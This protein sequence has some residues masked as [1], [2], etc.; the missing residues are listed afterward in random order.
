MRS[1]SSQGL[2]T[3]LERFTIYSKTVTTIIL[4]TYIKVLKLCNFSTQYA[5]LL[6]L[7]LSINFD[8]SPN[9]H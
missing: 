2:F 7:G 4:T 6:R 8:D 9:H 5:D 1:P 3:M